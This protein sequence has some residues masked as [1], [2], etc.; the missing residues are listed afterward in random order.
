[1]TQTGER[2]PPGSGWRAQVR[3]RPGGSLLLKTVA[4]VVGVA[5]IGLGVVLVV[6]PGP[7][8]IPP[9][10]LGL[11]VLS[12]EFAWADRLFRRAQVSGRKAWAGARAKPVSSAVVT[13]GGLV[14]AGIVIWAVARYDVVARVRDVLGF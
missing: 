12:L 1:M 5:L 3:R 9:I 6:L 10:L 4:L 8:T 11:Y 7:L 14:V 2:H 13:V